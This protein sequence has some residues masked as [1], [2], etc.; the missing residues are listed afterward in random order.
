MFH[1]FFAGCNYF[2][3]IIDGDV[4]EPAPILP[5]HVKKN[6]TTKPNH[7]NSELEE[8]P[9]TNPKKNRE[10]PENDIVFRTFSVSSFIHS[11]QNQ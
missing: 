4:K 2:L 7:Q 8:Y 3:S 6:K 1:P 5:K 11:Q 9:T 10:S